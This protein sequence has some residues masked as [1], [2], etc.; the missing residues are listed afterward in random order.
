MHYSIES[1]DRIC[2][3]DYGFLS[4]SKNMY[5]NIGKKLKT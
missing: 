4:F 1:R 2:V 3:K 5:K